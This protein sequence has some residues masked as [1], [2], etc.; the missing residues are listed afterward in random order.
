MSGV[1]EPANWARRNFVRAPFGDVRRVRR[2]LKLARAMAE[3][4]G[5]SLVGLCKTP[6]D[7][8]ATY[9]F[10]RHPEVTPDN[11]QHC[12]REL[13]TRSLREP[14]TVSLLLEDTSEISWNTSLDIPDLGPTGDDNPRVKGFLLHSVLAVRWC[15]PHDPAGPH[16]RPAAEV[17]GLA[18]QEYYLRQPIPSGEDGNSS[19]ARLDR[20]RESQLWLRSGERLGPAPEGVRFVRVADRGADIYEYLIDCQER[21]HGFVV[22]AAQDRSL[23]ESKARLFATVRSLPAWAVVELDV[24]ERKPAKAKTGRKVHLGRPAHCAKLA[25]A[26]CPVRIM[27]PARAEASKGKLQPVA[28]TAVRVWELDPPAGAEPLEWILLCDGPVETAATALECVLQYAT[29][30]VVEDFH[31]AL[32]SGLGAERLRL[33]TGHALKAAVALMSIG[34]LRL[35]ELRE[36][37]RVVPE[38]K[39]SE[40]GLDALELKLLRL[41]SGRKLQTIKDVA[42]ALGRL[43]G[44]MN[45]KGDGMPGLLTLWRDYSRLQ[46]LTRGARMAYQISGSG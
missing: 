27:S 2:L 41:E 13:T 31:K 15:A 44:H 18:H 9:K 11:L 40:A 24:R 4:P 34:A 30:W 23:V 6:Y 32:K 14:G 10:L 20:A 17:L 5:E 37:L 3:R 45:R 28:C 26:A 29:R 35:V 25:V 42:L 22:R 12:H 19:S 33:E 36:R 1:R 16:L 7:V 21:R 38:A 8:K 39:A 46:P 43:G